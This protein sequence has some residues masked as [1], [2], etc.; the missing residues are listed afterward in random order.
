MGS[1]FQLLEFVGQTDLFPLEILQSSPDDPWR[2]LVGG[3]KVLPDFHLPLCV[4]QGLP[5]L[6][7]GDH[8]AI[9]Y[10]GAVKK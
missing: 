1:C 8:E 2:F 5:E 9:L 10:P 6:F 4:G 7:E 3:A